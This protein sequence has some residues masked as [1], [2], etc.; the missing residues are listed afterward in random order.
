M[1]FML[2]FH[3]SHAFYPGNE[4][5]CEIWNCGS[6]PRPVREDIRGERAEDGSAKSDQTWGLPDA[7][8]LVH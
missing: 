2:Y 5:A 8:D 6:H 3:E 1:R 7:A 4:T